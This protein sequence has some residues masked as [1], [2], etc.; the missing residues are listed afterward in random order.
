[1]IERGGD[2]AR[3]DAAGKN[4]NMRRTMSARVAAAE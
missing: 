4:Q 2:R 3:A 1:M